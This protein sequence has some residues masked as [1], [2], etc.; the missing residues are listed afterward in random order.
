MA[1]IS[2]FESD[3]EMLENIRVKTALI[4]KSDILEVYAVL[5]RNSGIAAVFSSSLS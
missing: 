1:V 5:K 3:V 2:P 4:F